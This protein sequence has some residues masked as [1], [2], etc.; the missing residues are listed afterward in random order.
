MR[1]ILIFLVLAMFSISIKCQ[2]IDEFGIDDFSFHIVHIGKMGFTQLVVTENYIVVFSTDML[3]IY[4]EKLKLVNVIENNRLKELGFHGFISIN[5]IQG[6]LIQIYDGSLSSGYHNFEL[7]VADLSF[8][9]ID[10]STKEIFNLN[11]EY[12]KISGDT[13]INLETNNHRYIENIDKPIQIGDNYL[14]Y[15]SINSEIIKYEFKSNIKEVMFTSNLSMIYS[16]KY[17]DINYFYDL[18]GIYKLENNE[19]IKILDL[20]GNF[21]R[22]FIINENNIITLA[23]DEEDINNVYLRIYENN[24]PI[25][26]YKINHIIEN[27]ERI[28]NYY[29]ATQI[30]QRSHPKYILFE[31]N[32]FDNIK[33]FPKYLSNFWNNLFLLNSKK[34]LIQIR[35]NEYL[36]NISK[37]KQ[38]FRIIGNGSQ[39]N[40]YTFNNILYTQ[41]YRHHNEYIH[42][43]IKNYEDKNEEII[44]INFNS[45][46][47]NM[48][49]KDDNNLIIL[50]DE[51]DLYNYKIADSTTTL[52]DSKIDKFFVLNGTLYMIKDNKLNDYDFNFPNTIRFMLHYN[53]ETII[54]TSK[55]NNT[56]KIVD[57]KVVSFPEPRKFQ[58]A[59]L[60]LEINDDFIIV[61]NI[62][63]EMYS[64]TISF[65]QIDNN[66]VIYSPA[67]VLMFELNT[68][69]VT[70]KEL[71]DFEIESI[72]DIN[73]NKLD[74]IE[75]NKLLLIQTKD[76]RI[77]KIFKSE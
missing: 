34:E 18:N 30:M 11:D 21:I 55:Y 2:I 54:L 66:L 24:L 76:N 53:D 73:G 77:L 1:K 72:Y 59:N 17:D 26:E 42:F 40:L 75:S 28:G 45:K 47:K 37:G 67:R 51:N 58:F 41:N 48:T 29:F 68:L 19:I 22:D 61:N 33:Y 4:D 14:I 64:R 10:K 16:K 56:Y 46:I 43:I 44:Q 65:Q 57:N 31:N 52:I 23:Q 50:D 39:F 35:G 70:Q 60:N 69:S 20:P 74:N 71:D 25:K 12:Y 36:M 8:R 27:I 5:K 3:F 63:F 13:L 38:E 9:E 6:D 62:Q 32:D 49:L 7:N 15:S